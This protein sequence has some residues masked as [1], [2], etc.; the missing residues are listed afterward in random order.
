MPIFTKYAH[1]VRTILNIAEA[2]ARL[3]QATVVVPSDGPVCPYKG[4]GVNQTAEWVSPRR[5]ADCAPLIAAAAGA[6]W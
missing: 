3:L 1:Q 5:P 6:V 4:R 2:M